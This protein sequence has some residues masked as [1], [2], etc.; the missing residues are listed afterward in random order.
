M[1]TISTEVKVAKLLGSIFGSK[2]GR[3]NWDENREVN[4][5][6]KRDVLSLPY[7]W[8]SVSSIN[9]EPTSS[10]SN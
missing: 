3:E 6:V 10:N 9:L 4:R 5:E 7:L 8:V 1:T 2:T